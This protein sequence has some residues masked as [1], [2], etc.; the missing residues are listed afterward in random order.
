MKK[1][2]ALAFA[3]VL[4]LSLSVFA[5]AAV[6]DDAKAVF[7]DLVASVGIDKVEEA[8]KSVL[9]DMDLG[10][11]EDL[12]A[13][14]LPAEA[15][16]DFADK[17]INTLKLDKGGTLANGI[18]SAMSNDFIVFL[19]GMYTDTTGMKTTEP[20]TKPA[21]VKPPKPNDVKTGDSS[22]F[23]IAAFATVSVAAAAAFVVLKKKED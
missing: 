13:G 4:A 1:I 8:V 22:L 3:L 5:F 11:A 10:K 18:E 23:A 2:F 15:S 9:A 20:A 6:T 16:N 7:D 21:V 19:A 14:D 17:I 12:N